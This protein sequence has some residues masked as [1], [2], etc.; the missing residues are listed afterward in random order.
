MTDPQQSETEA[1]PPS[2]STATISGGVAIEADQV[3]IGG[4]VV[5]RDKIVS[6]QGY[7]A[8]EVRTLL[9]Q[10]STTFQPRPFDG[11]CPYLGLVSYDED[12]ADLFFGREAVIHE[13]ISRVKDSRWVFVTGPSGS[14]KSSL[15][16]A[17]L[18]YNLKHTA[19]PDSDRWLYEALKPGRDPLAELARVASSLA[20][21]LNAGDDIRTK[22]ATDPTIL[23]Q[24]V[25]IALK[26]KRDR[27]AVILVDQFEETF[28]QIAREADRLAFLNLLTYAATNENGR[29]TIVFAM[30]SDF[31]SNCAAYPQLNDLLNQQ[32]LQ[33]GAMTPAELVSAI[34]QPALR[35]GLKVEPELVAQIIADMKGEPGA[36]PLVQFALRD[37]FDAQQAK[38]GIIALTLKDYLERGGIHKALERHADSSFAQLDEAEQAIAR[39]V[40]GGLIQV[41]RGADDTRRTALFDELVPAGIAPSQVTAVVGKLADA[42]LII[43]DERDGHDIVTIAHEKLIDAWPWLR[44]LVNDNRD[45]IELQNQI[46]EDAVE[47]A[48]QQRD[49]SYLYVGARLANAREQLASKKIVLN[50]L[51]QAFVNAGVEAET[52]NRQRE[53]ARIE[54]ELDDARKLAESEKQRA[55]E[56]TRSAVRLRQRAMYLIGALGVAVLLGIAAGVFGV[57]SNQNAESARRSA[58]TAEAASTLAVAN[59]STA[60]A[61]EGIRATAESNANA[62]RDEAQ[63]QS[64]ISLVRELAAKSTNQVQ[65]NGDIGLLLAVEAVKLAD[66]LGPNT[67]PEAAAALY[68]ALSTANFDRVLR[69]H[70]SR[71]T[72]VAFSPDSSLILTGDVDGQLRLWHID[73]TEAATLTGLSS[74]IRSAAFSPNG[75]FFVTGSADNKVQLWR[76]D[77]TLVSTLGE[78]GSSVNWVEFSPNGQLIVAADADGNA[79]VW[80]PDGAQVGAFNDHSDGI[81]SAHFNRDGSLI[82]TASSDRTARVWKPDGTPV[83]E[84]K[85]HTAN[86]YSA[87]FSPDGQRILTAGWDNTARLWTL[88]GELLTTLTGHADALNV[89]AFSPDGSLILTAS[90]DGTARLWRADGTPVA[91]LAGHTS[92]INAAVFSPDGSL[93]VTASS[94]DTARVWRADGTFVTAL[95]GHSQDVSRVAFSPDGQWIATGSDD[96]TVRLWK[97][98]RLFNS[99]L[100]GH[101]DWVNVVAY[102]PDGAS[103]LT[104]SDDSTAR[105]WDKDGR[106]LQVLSGHTSVIR[107]AAFSQDGSRIVTASQDG[108]ARL[109]KSD[110]TFINVFDGSQE[111]S[112][113]ACLSPDGTHL[114]TRNDNGPA[115]LSRDDGTLLAE[116]DTPPGTNLVD[117]FSPDGKLLAAPDSSLINARVWQADGKQVATLTGHTAAINSVQFSPDGSQLVTASNDGTARLWRTDGTLIRSLSV[118]TATLSSAMFSADGQRIITFHEDGLTR[119]WSTTGTLVAELP[120]FSA[121]FAVNAKAQVI[122]TAVGGQDIHLWHDDGTPMST[123]T[124]TLPA[125][126]SSLAF[127]RDGRTL[128]LGGSDGRC[129][130]GIRR[131]A[132]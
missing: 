53:S 49:T 31:V 18:I 74:E 91:T 72:V 59:A 27:R 26:D 116:L 84:L 29:T 114:V 71:L 112:W 121:P 58:A 25:E 88:N 15:V 81:N 126:L 101:T 61:V 79:F 56:Q 64:R 105:L 77:G 118:N 47:W 111:F 70:A 52:L 106:L 95:R 4:D 7:T 33:V 30:R 124:S 80:R 65:H 62:Q 78:L 41:G 43:T 129:N 123:F 38:G 110:G 104:A 75:Q 5:G 19:L 108:S 128:L 131:K 57:Q 82:V 127:S 55:E 109:W 6:Y 14:G 103:I 96:K 42:R 21:N 54:K 3:S 45:A 35:V 132:V 92:F 22:G 34:A 73:G 20:G 94:D 51:A 68:E 32:F 8:A 122:L 12:S 11:R 89:A 39:E 93:I 67:V 50:G 90:E 44:R 83:V 36:L 130:Y 97:V 46:A 117:C 63:R 28:T 9:D 107:W 40:F 16:R 24:W 66:R 115:H 113:A 125:G 100:N 85:A 120:G 119:I 2:Q 76:S 10:I 23:S 60:V 37:L 87:V 17:G 48:K 13:L 98:D 102:S 69:W 99:T 86:V 1:V